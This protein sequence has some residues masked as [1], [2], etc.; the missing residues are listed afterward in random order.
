MSSKNS[1]AW[2]ARRKV[3][4]E[5][6][7]TMYNSSAPVAELD[8]AFTCFHPRVV[9]QDPIARCTD[10]VQYQAQFRNLRVIFKEFHP[11]SVEMTGDYDKISID[12]T[13][14]WQTRWNTIDLRQVTICHI[15]DGGLGVI[16][17]HEDLWSWA[18]TWL[19]L[20][21]IS[22][23]YSRWRP[24]FGKR[25]SD[26]MIKKAEKNHEPWLPQAQKI[27]NSTYTLPA[28]NGNDTQQG[29]DDDES[30]GV[31]KVYQGSTNGIQE[32][33]S[34]RNGSSQSR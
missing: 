31:P 27:A 11:L 9:F 16:T 23:C 10:H 14:R 24:W 32:R 25:S 26:A 13:V 18:D 12:T 3:L 5:A 28:Q 8:K 4:T 29:A 21:V 1:Q 30:E 20:P 15:S 33:T 19:Q 34:S 17:K 2:R 6:V 7:L 22:F